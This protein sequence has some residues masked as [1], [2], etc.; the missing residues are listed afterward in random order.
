MDSLIT[1]IQRFSLHDGPGIRTTIFMKG[2]TLHC[3]WCS[4]PEN[5][6]YEKESYDTDNAVGVY[7]KY[8]SADDL[9]RELLK[10]KVYWDGGGGVTFSGGEALSHM[11]YLLPVFFKLKGYGV[12]IAV[13]TSLQVNHA[14]VEA[15]LKCVDFFFIDIKILEKDRCKHIIGGDVNIFLENLQKVCSRIQHNNIIFRVPCSRCYTL[16]DDNVD[17]IL[18]LV[19]SYKD[20]RMEIFLL[21][22]LGEEKYNSLH[23]K[24]SFYKSDDD[25]K[26]MLEFYGRLIAQ[27]NLVKINHI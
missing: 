13:E 7:G 15:A 24:Y 9:V 1:N 26:S 3:P 5:L 25:E 16:T 23:K 11:E 19:N 10:D 22:S 18:K 4:N 6:N 2:C 14:C 17:L 21:H 12:N 8:Y 27:G 20:I